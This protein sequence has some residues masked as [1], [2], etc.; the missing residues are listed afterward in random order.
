MK[1]KGFL[2]MSVLCQLIAMLTVSYL[3]AGEGAL[4]IEDIDQIRSEL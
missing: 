3:F 4:S 1:V 2:K